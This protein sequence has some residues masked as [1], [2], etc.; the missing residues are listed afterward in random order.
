MNALNPLSVSG[1]CLSAKTKERKKGKKIDGMCARSKANTTTKN[2]RDRTSEID[3]HL[4]S[5]S[6]LGDS[7]GSSG[8]RRVAVEQR[9]RA[10]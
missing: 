8:R 1:I 4:K 3:I 7:S 5:I 10:L 2:K 6:C 9:R